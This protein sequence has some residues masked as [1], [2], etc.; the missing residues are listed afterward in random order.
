MRAMTDNAT[1]YAPLHLFPSEGHLAP[2]AGAASV[3]VDEPAQRTLVAW[4]EG[5]TLTLSRMSDEEMGSHLQGLRG[6]IVERGGGEGLAIRALSTL[7]VYGM[8]IEPR[9]DPRGLAM[10]FVAG[11]TSATDG[12][13]LLNGGLHDRDG[14]NLLAAG[15]ATPSAERVALRALVMLTLSFRCLLEQDAGKPTE[16]EAEELRG[17]LLAWLEAAPGVQAEAERHELELLSSPIGAADGQAITNGVWRA[18]GAQVLLWALG[19]RAMPAHDAQEHPYEVAKTAGVLGKGVAAVCEAPE[20][21]APDEL[22]AMRRVLLGLHWRLRESRVN[23]GNVVDFVGFAADNWFGGF[24]PA[25]LATADGDLAVGGV[26][27]T[28]ADPGALSLAASTAM[29]RHQA[30]NWLIGAH[31][32]YSCVVTPT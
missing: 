26:A 2:F 6:F 30:I 8:T 3:V 22:D 12:L 15:A 32:T 25:G 4:P 24:D 29:E 16:G 27:L 14:T 20:L 11:L 31:P 5:P 13:C 9:F 18:E 21:R 17:E 23:P 19:A 10:N 7:S 1:V 28:A